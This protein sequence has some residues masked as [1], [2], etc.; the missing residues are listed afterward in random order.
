TVPLPEGEGDLGRGFALRGVRPLDVV[1]PLAV[2]GLALGLMYLAEALD[3]P[4]GPA[5]VGLA[6][7]QPG[8]LVYT[9]LGRP[10]RVRLGLA[11][12]LLAGALKR[13][14]KRLFLE[15]NFCGVVKVADLKSPEGRPFRALF[16][17]NTIHGQMSL[18]RTDSD[19]RREPLTYYHRSG[20]IGVVCTK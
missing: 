4:Q 13:K 5:R 2:G 1:L 14:E 3:L 19:G 6:L 9:L 7:G 18:D 11:A 12:Q 17:G 16:H 15:R 8:I 20:P 10:A